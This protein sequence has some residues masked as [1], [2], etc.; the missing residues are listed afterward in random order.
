MINISVE[1]ISILYVLNKIFNRK[2]H[3][4]KGFLM[5]EDDL[6][7]PLKKVHLEPWLQVMI[8]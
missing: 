2:T 3:C 8:H 4:V 1:N 7:G 6:R 5:S